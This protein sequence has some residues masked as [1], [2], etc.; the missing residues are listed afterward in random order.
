MSTPR[1]AY[2]EAAAKSSNAKLSETGILLSEWKLD[3]T[4]RFFAEGKEIGCFDFGKH[5]ATFTGDADASAKL[6]VNAIIRMWPQQGGAVAPAPDSPT[7]KLSEP[8]GGEGVA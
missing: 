2:E 4:V 3:H 1:N 8:A 7:G 5:P 6:F